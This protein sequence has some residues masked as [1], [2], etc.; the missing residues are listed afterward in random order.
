[1]LVSSLLLPEIRGVYRKN[2]LMS[3]VTWLGTGGI[4]DLI[5]K[6]YDTDDLIYFIKNINLPIDVIGATSNILIRDGGIK[7]SVIKLGKEFAYFIYKNNT[8]RVGGATLLSRLAYFALEHEIGGM[9]FLVGI[10]GTIGGGVAMNAGSYG[11]SM[12][13]ILKSVKAVNLENGEICVISNNEME[14][15][16]RGYNLK[17]KWI[18]IEAEFKIIKSKYQTIIKTIKENI[19]KKKKSQITVGRTAGSFF[20]NTT[21]HKAWK[22]IDKSGCR[23][24]SIGG[25]KISEKHC[26][27]LLNYNN[28]TA[29]DLEN[30][31]NEVQKRVKQKF[32]IDL[33][34]EVKILGEY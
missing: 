26:N 22:L 25:A 17:G 27:F 1:M 14:Y 9:E 7:N 10:P 33:E 29:S 13:D 16:Y 23:G 8:L 15:F 19:G 6:P 24:L 3:R 2:T 4:A 30:L 5:F 18:F 28:A 32:N 11:S 21:H 12:S 31:G 34:W 20:K